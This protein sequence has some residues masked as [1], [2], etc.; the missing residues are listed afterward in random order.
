M[1]K[2]RM[3]Q[4]EFNAISGS[5]LEPYKLRNKQYHR[6]VLLIS[7]HHRISST[8]STVKTTLYSITNSTTG[9]Y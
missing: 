2:T 1:I 9:K 8:D 4:K 5:H 6:E 7:F 3:V